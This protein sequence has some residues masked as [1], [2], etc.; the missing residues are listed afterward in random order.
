M[1]EGSL[2]QYYD[3]G[4]MGIWGRDERAFEDLLRRFRIRRVTKEFKQSTLTYWGAV[5]TSES[6]RRDYLPGLAPQFPSCYTL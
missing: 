3:S 1:S 6:I 2:V 4:G 5:G